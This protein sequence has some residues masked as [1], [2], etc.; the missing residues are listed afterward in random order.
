MPSKRLSVCIKKEFDIWWPLTLQPP[1]YNYLKLI[2]EVSK[3]NNGEGQTWKAE[4]ESIENTEHD[5]RILALEP[6][7]LI[8]GKHWSEYLS[9]AVITRTVEAI[10]FVHDDSISPPFGHTVN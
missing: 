2:S 6:D 5:L 4:S 8:D 10:R 3:R 7:I 9:S 1:R